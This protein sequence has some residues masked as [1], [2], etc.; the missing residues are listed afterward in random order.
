MQIPF[1]SVH[2]HFNTC[3]TSPHFMFILSFLMIRFLTYLYAYIW[4][5]SIWVITWII[6][7]L[8]VSGIWYILYVF[9]ISHMW[10]AVHY[11]ISYSYVTLLFALL[12]IEHD[13]CCSNYSPWLCRIIVIEC[14][15]TFLL[16]G[17]CH[18]PFNWYNT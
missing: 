2:S 1:L 6:F 10:F 8:S 17:K 18:W 11:P 16:L 15:H 3:K 14:M 5:I 7:S 12:R 4:E 9:S 13:V